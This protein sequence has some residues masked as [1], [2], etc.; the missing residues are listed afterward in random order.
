[1][2]SALDYHIYQPRNLLRN[3]GNNSKALFSIEKTIVHVV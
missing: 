3:K 2:G 1:M